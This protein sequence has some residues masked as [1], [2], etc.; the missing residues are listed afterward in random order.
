[1][2]LNERR[3]KEKNSTEHIDILL[4][5]T[6]FLLLRQAGLLKRGGN[7]CRYSTKNNNNNNF[8]LLEDRENGLRLEHP[9]VIMDEYKL[10][11]AL[12]SNK[13]K[14][15]AQDTPYVNQI[16]RI[17][18]RVGQRIKDRRSNVVGSNSYNQVR[19]LNSDILLKNNKPAA[20]LTQSKE[21]STTTPSADTV[22]KMR[23][24]LNSSNTTTAHDW[25]G[26]LRIHSPAA[27]YNYMNNTTVVKRWLM[28]MLNLMINEANSRSLPVMVETF[29]NYVSVGFEEGTDFNERE[30]YTLTRQIFNQALKV[31]EPTEYI[32][33]NREITPQYGLTAE[34]VDLYRQLV[35]LCTDRYET[36]APNS[37]HDL[38]FRLV[39][40]SSRIDI[41]DALLSEQLQRGVIPSGDSID[42]LITALSK[43]IDAQ[44]HI[45]SGTDE[46]F[47]TIIK[48]DLTA[49]RALLISE[50]I[51]PSVVT[52]LLSWAETLDEVYSILDISTNAR[53]SEAILSTCQVP[54]INAVMRC[55]LLDHSGSNQSSGFTTAPTTH[56]RAMAHMF[57]V[58]NRFA[59]NTEA[60]ITSEAYDQCLLLSATHG[61]S[62][63]MYRS[64]AMRKMIPNADVISAEIMGRV[65][66][67]LPTAR[68]DDGGEEHSTVRDELKTSEYWWFSNDLIRGSEMLDKAV[69]DHLR[70]MVLPSQKNAD[71]FRRYIGALG[72][73]KS[74]EPLQHEWEEIQHDVKTVSQDVLLEFMSA[75][76]AAEAV[77]LGLEVLEAVLNQSS[78]GRA[79]SILKHVFRYEILPLQATLKFT[80]SW[81]IRQKEE[82]SRQWPVSD[83]QKAFE[84]ITG[85][86]SHA[87]LS[88]QG[89]TVIGEVSQAV[90]DSVVQV[91]QGFDVETSI[92]TLNELLDAPE[93]KDY[94]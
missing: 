64:L 92:S 41:A 46:E 35:D 14:S 87:K 71:V 27:S 84:E 5:R 34:D 48:H 90:A 65:F 47:T 62:T 1:M 58:L 51:S 60:G 42:V 68:Q 6:E 54:I 33:R 86:D 13:R 89:A 37:L 3:K 7:Y 17:R 76:R 59:E 23:S 85:P 16:K 93:R 10:F 45:F 50:N 61:N 11:E 69:L 12:L 4:M 9:F 22:N 15:R 26:F 67:R 94:Y 91:R 72:R 20:T 31:Y 38:L 43:H 73:L 74:S 25:D 63:G 88:P 28:E 79:M 44:R 36:N 78:S 80:A 8:N 81:F 55:A 66:D 19:R 21:H 56:L 70:Q 39:A 52:F 18:D 2:C 82:Q 49:Y 40:Q 75:F 32:V 57:G 83:I 29:M 30:T 24:L 53:Q 77:P